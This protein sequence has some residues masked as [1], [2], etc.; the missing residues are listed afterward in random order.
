MNIQAEKLYLIEWLARTSKM[1]VIKKLKAVKEQEEKDWWDTISASEKTAIEE[2][3]RQA[4]RG[5]VIPNKQVMS[6]YKKWLIK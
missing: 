4:D 5:E 6:K 2:G 1:S 3:L